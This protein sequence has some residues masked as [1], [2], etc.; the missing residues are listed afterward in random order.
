MSELFEDIYMSKM[1]ERLNGTSR[2]GGCNERGYW[3]EDIC[4]ATVPVP[5]NGLR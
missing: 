1:N 2:M 3:N 4:P 5:A